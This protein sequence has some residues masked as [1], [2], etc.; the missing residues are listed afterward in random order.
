[1]FVS[2]ERRGAA[3]PNADAGRAREASMLAGE[4]AHALEEG[5][6]RVYYQ[7]LV[8]LGSEVVSEVEALVRWEHPGRGLL[9]PNDFIPLAEETG[10]IV[11]LGR[12]VLEEACGRVGSLRERYPCEPLVVG[13]NVSAVQIARADLVEDVAR[14]LKGSALPPRALKLEVTE[15]R[16]VEDAEAAAATLEALKDMGVHIAIDDFGTGHSSLSRLRSLPVDALK[17][18]RSFVGGLGVNPE[19][20]AIVR[21]VVGLAK[22]LDMCVAAEGIETGEQVARL[23]ALGCDLGQGYYFARPLPLDPVRAA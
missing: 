4:M 14:I 3:G 11:P 6:F 18:D 15:S 23:R 8:S 9:L 16:A 22:D 17:I 21:A 5:Q 7:P 19:D 1:M 20:T 2:P 12:W 10:L 13:V